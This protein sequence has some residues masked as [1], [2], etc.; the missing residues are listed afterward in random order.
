MRPGTVKEVKPGNRGASNVTLNVAGHDYQY[1]CRQEPALRLQPGDKVNF[2]AEKK[3]GKSGREYWELTAF[4]LDS[5]ASY[6]TQPEQAPTRY[7]PTPAPTNG[8]VQAAVDKEAHMGA[9]SFISRLHAG[10]GQFPGEDILADQIRR[11]ISAWKKATGPDED[12]PF[13]S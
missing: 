11:Y 4:A 8:L 5:G 12:L 2:A 9:M 1:F 6:R 3:V 7:T 13:E 10:T